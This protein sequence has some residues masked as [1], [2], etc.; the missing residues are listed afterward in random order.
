MPLMPPADGY[1]PL[2]PDPPDMPSQ[3][4]QSILHR[5]LYAG[6]LPDIPVVHFAQHADASVFVPVVGLADEEDTVV[7]QL[8]LLGSMQSQDFIFVW[9]P[10]AHVIH[11]SLGD[12]DRPVVGS[13]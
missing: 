10:A 1:T 6:S 13:V 11:I 9:S 5:P 2:L 8:P 3:Y 4:L 7:T 12:C